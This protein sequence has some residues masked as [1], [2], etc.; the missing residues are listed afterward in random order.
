M[1]IEDR[2]D[3]IDAGKQKTFVIRVVN[4]GQVPD[5]QVTLAVVLPPE[6][7][8][9]RFSTVGPPS[10]EPH[11][12]G[13]IIRFDPV[14]QIDVGESLEYR[15]RVSAREPGDVRIQAELSSQGLLQQSRTL[16]SD[17]DTLINRPR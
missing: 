8:V 9:V 16:Q 15:I 14:E 6:M 13:S 12:D 10:T 1:T 5:Y 11:F 2:H 7:E 17:E 3:P 4:N